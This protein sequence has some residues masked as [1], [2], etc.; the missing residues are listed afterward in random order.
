MVYWKNASHSNLNVLL[1]CVVGTKVPYVLL[2]IF[3]YLEYLL[4]KKKE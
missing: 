3:E 4:I 1:N 2:G